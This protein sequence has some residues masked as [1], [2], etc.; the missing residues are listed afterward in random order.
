M[1]WLPDLHVCTFL[2]IPFLIYRVSPYRL[3]TAL[4]KA[5]WFGYQDICQILIEKGASV[6][7]T[8][9]QG[10]TPYDKSI[11]SGDVELQQYM[12]RKLWWATCI[13][14]PARWKARG[15][16]MQKHMR[17]IMH[18][19]RWKGQNKRSLILSYVYHGCLISTSLTKEVKGSYYTRFEALELNFWPVVN[20]SAQNL[21]PLACP[22][23]N[24]EG[25]SM[26][27]L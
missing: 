5:A 25:L 15:P 12:K 19:I 3:Q 13:A 6:W 11:Q 24:Y 23:A 10:N 9:Y 20:R 16:G 21:G 4:H 14:S 8:D 1:T 18:G 26:V 17:D 22:L 7:I 27:S 2:S